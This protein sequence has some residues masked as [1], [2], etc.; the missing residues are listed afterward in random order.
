MCLPTSCLVARQQRRCSLCSRGRGG[1]GTAGDDVRRGRPADDLV[2]G[3]R[4]LRIGTARRLMIFSSQISAL[5][6]CR[7]RRRM[8]HINH[9]QAATV[10]SKITAADNDRCSDHTARARAQ[11]DN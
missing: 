9:R 3:L 8:R 7:S 4:D 11:R 6:R 2:D 5:L 1:T 10:A